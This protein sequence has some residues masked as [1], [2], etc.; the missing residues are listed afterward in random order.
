LFWGFLFLFDFRI[1]GFDVLPDFIGYGLFF[2]GATKLRHVHARFAQVRPLCGL[3]I[4]LSLPGLV[5]GQAGG[6]GI[7]WTLYAFVLVAVD[8]YIV[9][10]FC[11]GIEE[12]AAS[13]GAPDLANLARTRWTLYLLMQ[14]A[15]FAMYVGAFIL[16]FLALAV[17]IPFLIFSVVVL[18]LMMSLMN[19]AAH[20][21]RT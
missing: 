19:K 7:L 18:A 8:L 6:M 1:N 5:E 20:R 16:P 13:Q 12:T 10:G 21:L 11:R 9:Y 2:M 17:V 3:M 15:V 4:I 14:A